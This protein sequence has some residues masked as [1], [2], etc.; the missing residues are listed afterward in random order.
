MIQA[1]MRYIRITLLERILRKGYTSFRFMYPQRLL[2][3]NLHPASLVV[4]VS[5]I[6]VANKP[7][8]LQHTIR[9]VVGI[10]TIY[11]VVETLP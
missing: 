1:S 9:Q 8:T 6:K 10:H 4:A 2:K 5:Y 3:K 7:N 11:F